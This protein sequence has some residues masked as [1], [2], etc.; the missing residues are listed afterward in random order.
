MRVIDIAITSDFTRLVAVGMPNTLPT[1]ATTNPPPP[2][3][4]TPPV[5]AP[6]E[7]NV[8]KSENQFIVYDLTTKQ[9]KQYV[10]ISPRSFPA[11]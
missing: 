7:A 2:D 9:V 8:K 5:G 1:P 11:V 3:A 4:G 6:I 10:Y